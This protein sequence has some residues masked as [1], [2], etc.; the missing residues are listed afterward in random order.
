MKEKI[1]RFIML[2][3]QARHIMNSG[4]DWSTKFDLIFSDDICIAITNLNIPFDWNDPDSG[5]EDDVRAFVNAITDKSR[6][7]MKVLQ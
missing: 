2:T 4:A 6:E 3:N 1:L 7:L 5:Y